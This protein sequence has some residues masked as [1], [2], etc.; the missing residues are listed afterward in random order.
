VRFARIILFTLAA[1]LPLA[2]SQPAAYEQ[3]ALAAA[4]G[5]FG[6]GLLRQLAAAKPNANVFISPL[7]VMT[8]LSMARAGAAGATET[9]MAKVMELGELTRGQANQ[10][11]A[12]QAADLTAADKSVVLTIANSAWARKGVKF[13][14]AFLDATRSYFAAQVSTLDFA[15]PSAVRKING[16]VKDKTCGL[17]PEIVSRLDPADVLVLV[18]AVYF[19]GQWS[20]PFE[21]RMSHEEWFHF[22]KG[23]SARRMMMMRSD[24]MDY[25]GAKGFDAVRLPYGK[26]RLAMYLFVPKERDGIRDL[27]SALTPENWSAWLGGFSEA[28]GELTLPRFKFEYEAGLNDVLNRMGMGAAFDPQRADF[29]AMVKPPARVYI[30]EVKHKTFVE[31]NEE[32]T[33]AAA[34]TSTRLA[35]TS[36]RPEPE[37]RFKIVADHPFLCAIRDEASGALLF[38]GVVHDP[39]Q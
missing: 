17:I 7:S 36:V 14:Q 29:G 26:G 9:A 6:V 8:C 37:E 25:F 21:K 32:G 5:R 27:L 34:V 2:G 12:A 15:K 11:L 10:A 22:A 30:S 4:Q 24:R 3:A 28:S 33:E 35:L 39:K 16:W 13:Q 31:V 23:D 20:E 19:K 38:I 1:A 18:N